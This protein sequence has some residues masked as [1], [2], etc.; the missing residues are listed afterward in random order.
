MDEGEREGQR[1]KE[2]QG[3]RL[4]RVHYVFSTLKPC[5]D[6]SQPVL[7]QFTLLITA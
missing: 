4:S 6:P 1:D 3:A 2:G 5:H 7:S